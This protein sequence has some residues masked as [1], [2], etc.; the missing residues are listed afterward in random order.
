M[1]ERSLLLLLLAAK[2]RQKFRS[3]STLCE[4]TPKLKADRWWKPSHFL[5]PI[6]ALNQAARS[7]WPGM[8]SEI[9]HQ[10]MFL[11]EPPLVDG[12]VITRPLPGVSLEDL[13]YPPQRVRCSA[14]RINAPACMLR[15]VTFSV[16][17]QHFVL[18]NIYIS[19]EIS[20]SSP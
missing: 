10:G 12:T 16:N 20:A 15:I 3:V 2:Y 9:S 1:D 17:L 7:L 18:S 13:M 6:T 19:A 14:W 11:L 8:S 5:P 4:H